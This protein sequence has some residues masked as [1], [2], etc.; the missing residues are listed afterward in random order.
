[1][2]M[3]K[4]NLKN[5]YNKDAKYRELSP[6]QDWKIRVRDDFCNLLSKKAK[7]S[8][9]EI[10]A[11]TGH[12]SQYFMEKGLQ[13]VA[14][15]LS[16]EMVKKCKEKSIEAYE[17]DFYDL[18][19]LGRKFDCIWA[20]NT[21]LHVPKAELPQVLSQ[22]DSVLED[23][24]LFYMGVYGG[25]DSEHEYALKEVSDTPRFF[26]FYLLEDLLAVLEGHFHIISS[27]E[28]LMDNDTFQSIIMQK[29]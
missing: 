10:G 18:T 22:I 6:K 28:I 19:P 17:M 5:F 4:E 26:S 14:I 21:L 11:G 20:M 16:P 2:K 8:L 23:G 1:M 7:Q 15:D 27:Q 24:G 12:D 25:V 29:H 9:L 3:H 13:V